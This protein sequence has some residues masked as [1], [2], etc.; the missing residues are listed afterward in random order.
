M[1]SPAPVECRANIFADIYLNQRVTK[2]QAYRSSQLRAK[3]PSIINAID[4]TQHQRKRKFIGQ[5]LT[6]RSMRT[7]E[8]EM[9]EQIEIFLQLLLAFC[10][11]DSVV[12]M[13]ERC[14][15][16]GMDI[17]GLLSFGYPFKTQTGEDFRFLPP[18]IEAMSWRISTYMQF[19]PLTRLEPV[20]SLVGFR[21]VI[22]FLNSVR[23][24]IKTRMSQ[25]KNAH[26]DLYSI[27]ADHIGKDQQGLYQ[28]ELWPEA[29]LFIIAGGATTA[30]AMSALFFYLSR[31][32]ECYAAL[33][34]E[35]R[36]KFNSASDIQAGPQLNACKYLRACIDEALRMSPPSLTALWREQD[37]ADDSGEPF[38]VDGHVI[39]RGTQVGVSLY[40]IM[41]NEEYFPDSFSFKPERW[42]ESGP[43]APAEGNVGEDAAGKKRK[44]EERATMRKAFA[45]FLIGDRSCAGRSM[46]Y[47]E[48][49]L[50]IARTFWYFDFEVAPEKAGELG[51]GKLGRT[52]GRGRPDEYQLYDIF[53]AA[54]QGPNL[55]FRT[56][57]DFWKELQTDG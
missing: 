17:V 37:A 38:I 57:G 39:P 11:S 19:P 29:I 14:Q 12:N 48:T 8:P 9:A 43:D 22:K 53:V 1:Y 20:L 2:G 50:T 40:S 34:D 44:A 45:P 5:V 55:V 23:A 49:S 41:H 47:M 32:P 35:I 27:V 26:H 25:D 3:Y 24:M 7:F 16:L 42:L 56:R 36:S 31:N 4:Q 6:E 28:G 30:T 13:T 54:H 15:R 10:R 21:Q 52:D 33:A 46:A 18:V 51:R